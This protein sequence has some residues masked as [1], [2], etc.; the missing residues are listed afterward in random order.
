MNRD[1]ILPLSPNPK[2]YESSTDESW[3]EEFQINKE[4]RF[5]LS[6]NPMDYESSNDEEYDE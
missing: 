5:P 6:R 2:D 1:S 4:S 3:D